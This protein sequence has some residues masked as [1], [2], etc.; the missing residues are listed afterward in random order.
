VSPKHSFGCKGPIAPIA[1]NTAHVFGHVP[2]E[3]TLVRQNLVA[4]SAGGVA[5]VNV[6]VLDAGWSSFVRLLAHCTNKT[7]ILFGYL[8]FE[9]PAGRPRLDRRAQWIA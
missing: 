3:R 9:C 6:T 8:S 2:S 4:D 1:A 5:K 7:A